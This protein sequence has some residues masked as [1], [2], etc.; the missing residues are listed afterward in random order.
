MP[1]VLVLFAHPRLEKS[2]SNR[3]LL[4]HLPGN[5][6]FR[7]LYER[8]PDFNVNIAEEQRQ[9]LDHDI[10]VF[11]HPLYWYSAPPLLK[12]WIDL[13]LSFG[14]A[15]GPQGTALK[16]KV[17][18]HVL[19]TGGPESAYQLDGFHG[20]TL[21]EFLRPLQRTM[22][23]C[24][25]TW[26]PPFVVHGTHRRTDE[27]LEDLG[28]KYGQ[29]LQGLAQGDLRPEDLGALDRLNQAV[30]APAPAQ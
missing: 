16:A 12:Q 14:W 28:N 22:T 3:A 15:Y 18:F 5:V 29:L 7:D 13:V 6:T 10:V 11:H 27:E 9:L 23:L 30:A 20:F 26:L 17:A 19:T 21:A 1:K 2:R 25:M 24:G 4:R 8:Y